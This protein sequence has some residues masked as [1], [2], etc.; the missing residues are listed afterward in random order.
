MMEVTNR[1]WDV[2][3]IVAL[4]AG[5]A[6]IVFANTTVFLAATV[7]LT[8]AAYGYATAGPSLDVEV[9]RTVGDA[10]PSAGDLVEVEVR[11]HNAGDEDVAEVRV[12]DDPPADLRVVDGAPSHCTSL[13]PG[14]T[15]TFA[16]TLQ[17]ERGDHAFG[18]L[19][20][21]CRN[22]SGAVERRLEVETDDEISVVSGLERLPLASQTVQYTGRVPTD[23]GGEGLEF[24]SVREYHSEDPMNRVDWNRLARTGELRTIEFREHNAASVVVVVDAREEV[25]VARREGEEDAV[26]LG[27]IAAKNVAD[28]LLDWNNLVGVAI[29]GEDGGYVEPKVGTDQRH[30]VRLLLEEGPRSLA[31]TPGFVDTGT[32]RRNDLWAHYERLN[33]RLPD[34]SQIVFVSPLL[35]DDAVAVVRQLKSHGHAVT[36]LSPDVTSVESLGGTVERVDRARRLSDVRETQTRAVEWAVDEGLN[37]AVERARKRWASR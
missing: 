18:S 23:T 28:A 9:E 14:E 4:L 11:V 12:F 30:R 13:N 10:T 17:V 36:V 19:V 2:G 8:Y 29:A 1:R 22:V 3:L 31:G 27:K 20:V 21:A 33:D 35:D 34:D 24:Y 7:G 6:G 15:A 26:E 32:M 16:Y 37:T 5:A 25:A